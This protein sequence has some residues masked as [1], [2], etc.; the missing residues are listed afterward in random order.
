[1][2]THYFITEGPSKFDLMASLFD[3]KVVNF[4]LQI[5]ITTPQKT[6]KV[7]VVSVEREDYSKD[8]WNIKVYIV[9]SP[10]PVVPIG[11]IIS[12]YYNSRTRHGS[13]N[14]GN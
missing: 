12:A 1:M 9:D 14:L 8:S 10:N 11:K 2:V 4:T 5:E 13:I 6:L 3:G 7:S